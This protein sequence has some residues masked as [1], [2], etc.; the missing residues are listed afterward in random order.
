[1][2]LSMTEQLSGSSTVKGL[3]LCLSQSV[4]SVLV[5]L[6]SHGFPNTTTAGNALAKT[7]RERGDRLTFAKRCCSLC[8]V[9]YFPNQSTEQE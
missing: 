9:W 3:K 5:P 4:A 2:T 8:Y 7:T 6:H 1:M